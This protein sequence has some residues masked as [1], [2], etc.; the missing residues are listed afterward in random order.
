MDIPMPRRVYKFLSARYGLDNLAK[1]RLKLSTIDDLNDPFDQTAVDTTHPSVEE[2]VEAYIRNFRGRHGILCFSRNWDNILLWSHYGASHTGI[3]LGFDIQDEHG[4]DV[5]YQPN[6][7][8]IRGAEE[9]TENLMLRMLRTKHESWSYE[10]EVR[11]VV[12][13][14]DP[15]DENGLWWGTF[16]PALE[17]KEVIAGAQ[18]SLEDLKALGAAIDRF[19]PPLDRSWAYTRKDAF[20][21]VRHDFPPPWLSDEPLATAL[22]TA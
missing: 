16:G 20:L 17:L 9:I 7:I 19:D 14:N 21:L 18:C 12:G 10:Q 8:R 13:L 2:V 15:P 3:C 5:H 11:L 6:L 22:E 4:I 1:R